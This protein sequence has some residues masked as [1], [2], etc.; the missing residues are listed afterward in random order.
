MKVKRDL[1]TAL[2]TLS[3]FN[4]AR[5]LSHS[6]PS[7]SSFSFF[8]LLIAA[9]RIPCSFFLSPP[10]SPP[11]PASRLSPSVPFNIASSLVWIL[12]LVSH[13]HPFILSSFRVPPRWRRDTRGFLR[14]QRVV[15]DTAA[16]LWIKSMFNSDDCG[17]LAE[18]VE[19]FHL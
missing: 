19:A 2:Q 5:V 9:R 18:K 8:P 13:L 12:C 7:D 1:N 15:T 17:P 6:P 16:K 11:L 14:R 10:C 4:S 3:P